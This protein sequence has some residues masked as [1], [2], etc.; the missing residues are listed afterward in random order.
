MIVPMDESSVQRIVAGQAVTDLA[1]AVKELV[2]NALD[3]GAKTINIR[4]FNQ[5]MDV[6][7]VSDDGCGVPASCRPFLAQKHATSKIS[8]FD[9]IYN[10]STMNATLGFRGEA[11]FCL[12]NLSANL[13][14]VTRTA[15]EEMGQKL[16]FRRDGSLLLAE[17][18][19][20][21]WVPRKVGTTVA[22]VQLFDALPVRRADFCKRIVAQR[23]K[24]FSLMQGYAIL[25]LGVAFNLMDCK[26][27]REEVKMRTASSAEQVEQTVSSVLGY[28]FVSGMCR[29]D[30]DLTKAIGQPATV[31]GLIS[32]SPFCCSNHQA[33]ELQFFSINNRPVELPK[34]SR[35][36]NDLWRNLDPSQRK[37][38]SCVL[39]FTLPLSAFDVNLSPDKRDVML[40]DQDEICNLIREHVQQVWATQS[41]GT[42]QE[43]VVVPTDRRNVR[44]QVQRR[45]AF[46]HD[47]TTVKLQH[48]EENEALQGTPTVRC[49]DDDNNNNN[50][51]ASTSDAERRQWIQVQQRFR[52]N[53]AP[54]NPEDAE[55][56]TPLEKPVIRVVSEEDTT[57]RSSNTL[58]Y[59]FAVTPTAAGRQDTARRGVFVSSTSNK[60]TKMVIDDRKRSAESFSMAEQDIRTRLDR[61]RNGLPVDGRTDDPI[62]PK[63]QRHD[64]MPPQSTPIVEALETKVDNMEEEDESTSSDQESNV[65]GPEEVT[66]VAFDGTDAVTS[67]AKSARL[68]KHRFRKHLKQLTSA[69]NDA[70]AISIPTCQ[71]VESV[72]KAT[73]SQKRTVQFS[74]ADFGDMQV[75]GQ[76][77]LGFILCKSK[78]DHQ[79]WI[80][81]QHACDEKYNFEALCRDT[82]LQEQRLIQPMPLDLSPSEEAC[83]L[84]HRDVF[85]A[86]GFRFE[87]N[88]DQPPRH[89]LSLTTLPHSGA[90]DGC[91]A[92]QFGKED[93]SALCCILGAEGASYSQDG[94][95]GVDGSGLYGNNAVRRYA[96][97]TSLSQNGE[98]LLAR[99]PKAIAMFA[100]RACRGS[101]MIGTALSQS[102]MEM[103][104]DRL[105]DVNQ[106]WNCP[107][108]RPT[109]RHVADLIPPM[110]EDEHRLA[111]QVAGPS[112][113]VMTQTCQISLEESTS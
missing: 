48:D 110:S 18:N 14:V 67:A 27:G 29:I 95:T 22:V 92:V 23:V 86:N 96:N 1:S 40:T 4:L 101:I 78:K 26:G 24:V 53:G 36:L 99:L 52:S 103:I 77:N 21:T 17:N 30:L 100:N 20:D 91:K 68:D 39:Q 33:R 25:C 72:G 75:L 7:E 47:F 59:H 109:M 32:K 83:I 9:D 51:N 106:P 62:Q 79:L 34:I 13:V 94:G 81:D 31:S 44:R 28:R 12:A 112:F 11:L 80:L 43:A 50:I 104:V 37:R 16:Q 2:D 90:R 85:E 58:Q 3:A 61:L 88:E 19:A 45:M 73:H 49:P 108:G 66:W 76:F 113:C 63:R 8:A 69:R 38:P 5:G 107:H 35:L 57:S 64:E 87:Y 70:T 54:I 65:D 111:T 55:E 74:K 15:D 98:R 89:R 97:S 84:E 41:E 10:N 82:K 105:K 46:V 42:F 93:V 6:V 71:S 102:E 56:A 60:N